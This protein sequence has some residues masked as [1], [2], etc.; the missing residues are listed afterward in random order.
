MSR[1]VKN[2]IRNLFVEMNEEITDIINSSS[3]TSLCIREIIEYVS[4]R[5]TAASL[6]YITDIYSEMSKKTLDEEI[7]KNVSNANKFYELNLRKKISDAYH[8]DIKDLDAYKEGIDFDEINRA[9][10]AAGASVGS[11]AVGGI[12]LGALSGIIDIPIV[13]V[14]A[15]AVLTGIT[16]GGVTYVKVVPEKNKYRFSNAV[17][18]FMDDLEGE[19]LSWVDEVIDFY[20]DNVN[21]LKAAL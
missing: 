6:G 17:V 7:F 3:S 18:A 1:E 10:A 15:G 8:F 5:I 12:L 16:G 19:M 11:A 9:Y 21:E 20:N 4:S 14:I 13:V 2:Y